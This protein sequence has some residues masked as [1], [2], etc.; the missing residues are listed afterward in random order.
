MSGNSVERYIGLIE[1]SMSMT[2]EVEKNKI[3]NEAHQVLRNSKPNTGYIH[4]GYSNNS[5][6]LNSGPSCSSYNIGVG[7]SQTFLQ[8]QQHYDNIYSY[9]R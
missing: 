3:I 6:G 1:K 7:Q 9:D 2:N 4:T 5:S 8:V